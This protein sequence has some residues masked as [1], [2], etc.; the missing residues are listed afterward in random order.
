LRSRLPHLVAAAGGA[1]LFLASPA[2]AAPHTFTIIVDK[3][4]FG[5]APANLARGDSIVFVNKDFLRHSATASDRSF[6]VDLSA[7]GKGRIVLNKA[8]TIN[9]VCRYHPGMRGVL[10]VR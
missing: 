7:N 2:G 3:M 10:K 5:P 4:K 8:G 9:Y 6:D 1:A